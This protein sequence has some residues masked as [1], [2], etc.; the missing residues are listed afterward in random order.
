MRM[1]PGSLLICCNGYFT[2]TGKDKRYVYLVF[3]VLAAYTVF[4]YTISLRNVK[5]PETNISIGSILLILILICFAKVTSTDPGILP[6]R[7]S[8]KTNY[9]RPPR[10][11]KFIQNKVI[12]ITYCDVCEIFQPPRCVHCVQCENCIL[13]FDHHCPWLG[14]CIGKR[15]YPYFFCILLFGALYMFFMLTIFIM[16]LRR[17]S[18][19]IDK[20]SDR[21]P[22]DFYNVPSILTIILF[23]FCVIM[24]GSVGL[25]LMFHVMF[26]V[27][28]T[29]TYEY[30]RKSFSVDK[31]PNNSG[32]GF[33]KLRILFFSK[34]PSYLRLW[35]QINNE[36]KTPVNEDVYHRGNKGVAKQESVS[37]FISSLN[38]RLAQRKML[39]QT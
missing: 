9:G 16:Y 13:E 17:L 6:R 27:K 11:Q 38:I 12:K 36:G 34:F 37:T 3:F 31:I 22:S 32:V 29:T 28:D 30:T 20:H 26:I 1:W 10:T 33:H 24:A 23:I 2:S 14:N 4:L 15:N 35:M 21:T 5:L 8:K 19:D 25:L 18:E 7:S 39:T